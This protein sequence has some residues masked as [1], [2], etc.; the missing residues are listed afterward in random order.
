MALLP[1][2]PDMGSTSSW[3]LK[4]GTRNAGQGAKSLSGTRSEYEETT[5][6][7]GL[8]VVVGGWLCDSDFWRGPSF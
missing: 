1:A 8:G 3:E 5:G 7:G 4:V 6:L 2:H